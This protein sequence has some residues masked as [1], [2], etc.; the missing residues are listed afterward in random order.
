MQPNQNSSLMDNS[1]LEVQ[2][3]IRQQNQEMMEIAQR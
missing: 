2:E 1:N 3:R